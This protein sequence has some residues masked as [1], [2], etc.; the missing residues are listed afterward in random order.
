[1]LPGVYIEIGEMCQEFLWNCKPVQSFSM[2]VM[3]SA[4]PPLH[5]YKHSESA[6]Y[7]AYVCIVPGT[8]TQYHPYVSTCIPG[9]LTY[10]PVY[11]IHQWITFAPPPDTTT[12]KGLMKFV[13]SLCPTGATLPATQYSMNI[14][15]M[16]GKIQAMVT[17]SGNERRLE[18]TDMLGATHSVGARHP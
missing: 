10:I 11:D 17:R 15:E 12:C 4:A 3:L 16:Y 2:H 6:A 13:G 8:Y 7:R 9:A 14:C 5:V 1:M 18:R